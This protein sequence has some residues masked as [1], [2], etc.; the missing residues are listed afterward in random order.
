MSW[1]ERLAR[2]EIVALAPYEHAAWL[3]QLERLHANELP[4]RQPRDA[5]RAGLNRYPEPQPR[6]LIARLAELYAVAPECL[7]VTRGSDEAIDL[8]VR[9]FC[10]AGEDAILVCTPTFGMYTLAAGIQGARVVDVPLRAADGFALDESAVIARC[11]DRVKL[12]FLCSPN[13]PT[14]NLFSA[15]SLL[16]I[17]AQ[18]EGRGLLVVDEAYIEFAGVPGLTQRVRAMPQL[19][20]LRTL[21]K[22]HALAGARCGAVIAA[23]ELI[24]LLR[25]VISPYAIAQLTVECVLDLLEPNK[26]AGLQQ[27]VAT[28][29]AERARLAQAL[30]SCRSIARIWP[31]AANFL[32]VDF[33]KAK[34]AADALTLASAAGLLIRDVRRQPGLGCALRVSIGTPAQNDRLLE[35]LR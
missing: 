22:A 9:A 11:T 34:G 27:R 21:S 10:R 19:V 2:P 16:R 6:E 31:S 18:L 28:I 26:L 25:K 12:V 15:E 13:N 8:L 3:P 32:L 23:A 33:D 14:G 17:A 1:A 20:V 5:T 4:W 35:A 30:Q 24:A 29:Q 7:L